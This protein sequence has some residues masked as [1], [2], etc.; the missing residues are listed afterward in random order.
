[1]ID[2]AEISRM[3]ADRIDDLC[4]ELLPAGC[5]ES[6][7]WRAGSLAGEAGGSLA[8]KLRRRPGRWNDYATGEYGDALDLIE[9]VLG[10]DT[11]E[12][13]R[14]AREWLGID[15]G[16]PESRE[17]YEDARRKRAIAWAA[18]EAAEREIDAQRL[19]LALDLFE[20]ADN[21]HGT[22]TEAYLGT[23]KLELPNGDDV[24]RHHPRCVFGGERVPC[25]VALFRHSLTNEP[26]GIQ[27]TR[28][29]LGG[30]TR[31][32]K[33]ERLNIGSTPAGSIKIDN[34]EDVLYGPTIAEG[35]E[36]G[37]ALRMLGY[38]PCWATGGKGTIRC[39]RVLP[40]P[41]QSLSIH[42]EPDADTDVRQCVGEWSSAGR[43]TI[44][45]RSL[46]GKDAADALWEGSP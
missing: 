10:C 3:L 8:I 9:G 17:Q 5:S 29:P 44:I 1:M 13:L 43:E 19:K 18:R 24:L 21:A 22:A 20:Q 14:W 2:A 45:L 25:M 30:W 23:R 16:T 41:V 39:F 35:L 12:A 28:L 42:S 6:G 37:L 11:C 32:M 40:E 31:G 27:R 34:D 26:V 36:T 15:Q 4:L 46:F 7:Y 38:R 33:M